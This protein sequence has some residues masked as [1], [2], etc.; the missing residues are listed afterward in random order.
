MAS[1]SA[2]RMKVSNECERA[3]LMLS[4]F[5]GY[6]LEVGWMIND[7]WFLV[8]ISSSNWICSGHKEVVKPTFADENLLKYLPCNGLIML[9]CGCLQVTTQQDETDIPALSQKIIVERSWKACPRTFE[10][11]HLD[12]GSFCPGTN[13]IQYKRYVK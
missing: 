8:S 10:A 1:I 6:V 3:T 7:H 11:K 4:T 2:H 5:V 13:C 9:P 12:A